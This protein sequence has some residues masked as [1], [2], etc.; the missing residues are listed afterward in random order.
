MNISK[1]NA[2]AKDDT[3][4]L[5]MI[6]NSFCYYFV[7]ELQG[8]LAAAGIKAN[9]CNVYYSG[10]SLKQHWTWWKNG[11]AHYE[12]YVTDETGRKGTNDV[13]LA[14]CLKQHD[15]DII[16][17]QEVSSGVPTDG[18]QKHLEVTET[19]WKDLYDYLMEQFPKA[20]F[21]WHQTWTYQVEYGKAGTPMTPQKQE[22]DQLQQKLFAQAICEYYG[23]KISRINSGRAWQICRTKYGYDYLTCRLAKDEG[24]GDGYH[25]GDIGGGQYLNACVWY[26]VLTGQSCLENSYRPAYESHEPFAEELM[27]KLRITRKENVYTLNEDFISILQ[28]SAHQAVALLKEQ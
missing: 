15:W 6:G 25:D 20:K 12:Y 4:N 18:A 9:V 27:E 19:Y 5:L 7:E 23:G 8:M 14:Y 13:D 24:R 26:E 16:S 1:T 28:N 22:E 21:Y 11:E 10:C 2:P 3:L 17:L